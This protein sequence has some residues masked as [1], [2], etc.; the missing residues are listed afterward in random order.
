MKE[1]SKLKDYRL[2]YKRYYGID[3]GNDYDVH[4]IDFDRTNNDIKNLLLLPKELHNHY[5]LLINGL[6]ENGQFNKTGLVDFKLS[7]P[8][9]TDYSIS[10]LKHLD[11]CITECKKWINL[12]RYKY[13]G[14]LKS[15]TFTS[16]GK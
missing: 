10:L 11:E 7:N 2:K 14:N 3:L 13:N 12:K 8:I 5:H 9:I 15:F 16:G 4:H 1:I 6:C